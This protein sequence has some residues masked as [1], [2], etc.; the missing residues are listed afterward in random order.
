[1]R[2]DLN[3]KIFELI[4]TAKL[5]TTVEVSLTKAIRWR[6]LSEIIANN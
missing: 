3:A 6:S 1:M 5:D 2:V 4:E